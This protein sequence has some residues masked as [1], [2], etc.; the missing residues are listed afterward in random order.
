MIY[1]HNAELNYFYRNYMKF[2]FLCK[3]KQN[4]LYHV[5]YSFK[6]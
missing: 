3:F 1:E 5:S 4:V 6:N 2:M